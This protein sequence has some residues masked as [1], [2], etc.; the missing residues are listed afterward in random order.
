M[1]TLV[2]SANKTI[3]EFL[4]D[5]VHSLQLMSRLRMGGAIPTLP[6]CDGLV[7][8]GTTYVYCNWCLI[9]KV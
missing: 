4:L 6:P 9:F 5:T 8:T 1:I 7:C 2:S 3:E